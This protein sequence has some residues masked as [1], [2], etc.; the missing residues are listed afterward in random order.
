MGKIRL[1]PDDVAS[2]VAAGEVVERP[3]SVVK[4]LVE[5][6]VDAGAGRITVE[7]VRGGTQLIRVVDDGC[8]MDR[9]DA[10]LSLERHAT[11]KIRTAGDLAA[12]TTMGFRGEAVPSIASVSR[13]RMATRP[14]GEDAGT[15][16]VVAGGKIES[17]SD[18]GEAPGTS[19]EI[20]SL[21]FN[22]PARRKF[23]R[24]E[25]TESAHIIHQMQA[26]AL[27]HPDVAMTLLRE[28]KMLWQAAATA[29][30]GVRIRDLFGEDFLRRMLPLEPGAENGIEISGFLSR[31][32]EGR[33]DR[34]Q[35]FVILNGRVVQCPAIFQP[36]REAYSE[37][38]PRGRHPLA[39]LCISMDPLAFDCNV[40]PAKREI[41]LH[42]PDQ[43]RQAVFL[44]AR[45]LLEN[46]RKPAIRVEPQV[47]PPVPARISAQQDAPA[48]PAPAP[49]A[50]PAAP[51]EPARPLVEAFR[52]PSQEPLN[53]EKPVPAQ[54]AFRLIGGLD[55][56][57][58]LME[59][60]DGLVLLNIR[61][62]SERI[63]FETMRRE[64][65]SGHV[66]MQRLLIPEVIELPVKDAVWISENLP[67]LQ[68][69]GFALE[70]FG[71]STFKI[72]ALPPALAGRDARAT[73]LD[74]CES[75]RAS[76]SLGNR[77]LATDALA[78]SVSV[79]A[80]M[81]GFAYEESR[82]AKLVRE[83]LTCELPY[84]SPRGHPTMIQWSFSELERKF[85]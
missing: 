57:W 68:S 81:D 72:E 76:G 70:P 22:L 52:P 43:L 37:A 73:L 1:L 56:R 29:D 28:G 60:N 11:S 39:V 14:H 35:Q 20:R 15:G 34:E 38:L 23:L 36:L 83:L 74:I 61:A 77:T 40:H 10:L 9:E 80:A 58:I 82:A 30:L 33:P 71:G 31:P 24:G 59:G 6:S 62:A 69:T 26:L 8:G 25:E 84:A 49:A 42:R 66:P 47:P 7:F 45:R 27:A 79:L 64:M 67:A 3:A 44:T 16:I 17:V 63:L 21:F 46:L 19:I 85:G 78:R 12:V 55:N 13:F 51:A 75:L 5:N 53:L 32:G 41:R 18:S 54:D 65:E 48:C 2:Q 4:E 50:V